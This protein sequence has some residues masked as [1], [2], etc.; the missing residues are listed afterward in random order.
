VS[1]GYASPVWDGGEDLFWLQ[2][3][4][5]TEAAARA[6][7]EA[8]VKFAAAVD[9]VKVGGDGF[10]P[11]AAD[12]LLP[13]GGCWLPSNGSLSGQSAS[14][15]GGWLMDAVARQEAA[16][17]LLGED[18]TN[19]RWV[20]AWVRDGYVARSNCPGGTNAAFQAFNDRADAVLAAALA[21]AQVQQPE[22][23]FTLADLAGLCGKKPQKGRK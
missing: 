7:Q 8:A 4:R 2:E 5:R 18:Y 16:A 1:I 21:P 20:Q 6:A 15:I 17:V 23:V 9:S 12:Q 22:Q 13:F 19:P 14:S 10:C 3:Q 11:I